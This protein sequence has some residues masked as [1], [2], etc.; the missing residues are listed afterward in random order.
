MIQ[1]IWNTTEP[2]Y[3][4]IELC[5]VHCEIWGSHYDIFG[6]YTVGQCG[7]QIGGAFWPLVLQEYGIQMQRDCS[8]KSQPQHIQPH[9]GMH[10]AFHSFF[11]SSGGISEQSFKTL[12]D[13]E[14]A[15][16]KARVS[17][18]TWT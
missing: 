2:I 5:Y 17:F 14:N 7:N 13:L 15:K 9:G 1:D 3:T 16:V 4:A 11:S 6:C 18:V 10:E 8:S 12:V